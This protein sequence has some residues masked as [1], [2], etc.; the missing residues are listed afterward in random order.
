[1]DGHQVTNSPIQNPEAR[2]SFEY[3]EKIGPNRIYYVETRPLQ[4]IILILSQKRNMIRTR[5][6]YY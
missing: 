6:L 4:N 1:M 2:Q 3:D 5:F